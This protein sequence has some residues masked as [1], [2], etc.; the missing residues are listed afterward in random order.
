MGLLANPTL[1]P[2]ESEK[3][4]FSGDEWFE[5]YIADIEGAAHSIALQTYIF[6]MDA[7]G[8][9]VLQ[10]LCN[11]SARGVAVQVIVDGFGSSASLHA[12]QRALQASDA[13]LHIYHPLPWHWAA[14]CL[15][16]GD[17]AARFFKRLTRINN[18]QHSKLC[19][20]DGDVAWTGSFNI[21]EDH[22][23]N[24][25]LRLDWKD[26][27][28]RVTGERCVLLSEFFNAVWHQD[29][30]QFSAYFQ[31]HPVTNF[32]PLLRKK[33][34][35]T[36]LQ[37]IRAARQRIWITS[38]Y[39]SPIPSIVLAL[40]KASLR[41]VDVRVMVP[42][43]SD[44]QFFPA[45]ASTYYV[46]LLR[47]GIHIHEYEDGILHGKHMVIDNAVSVGSSNMNHR[48]ALHDVELDVELFS[49]ASRDSVVN[50]FQSSLA[51]CRDI[52]LSNISRFYMWLL[53][54]GHIPR[55]LRYWL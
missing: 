45:L 35:R 28:V 46:D 54:L 38:A 25:G 7:V 6:E 52:T 48:S 18:R 40:K 15:E 26:C 47:A 29:R 32:S 33:R 16:R 50:A 24:K 23:E 49:V 39:F 42:E 5:G 9:R 21:T 14:T 22:L 4:F 31:L 36:L 11:A 44:V 1:P 43:H 8:R 51:K 2:W 37:Q 10:A 34:L 12:L 20:I 13:E 17:W 53:L 55:L 19:L 30:E 27:G 3:V 41:G